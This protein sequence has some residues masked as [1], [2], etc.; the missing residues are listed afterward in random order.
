MTILTTNRCSEPFNLAPQ[1]AKSHIPEGKAVEAGERASGRNHEV[2]HGH[3]DQD[4]VQVRAQL[5]VLNSTCYSEDI[6]G[7]SGH[8]QNEHDG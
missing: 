5:L 2:C 3:V 6:D 8:K 7:C 1:L 4:V